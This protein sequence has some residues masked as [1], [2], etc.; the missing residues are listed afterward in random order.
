MSTFTEDERRII[1]AATRNKLGY[2]EIKQALLSMCEDRGSKGSR[3]FNSR[4]EA[5]LPIGQKRG[6]LKHGTMMTAASTTRTTTG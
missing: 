4:M 2:N 1:K 3:P 6:T 5:A